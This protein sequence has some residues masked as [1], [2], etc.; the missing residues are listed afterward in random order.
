MKIAFFSSFYGSVTGGA[1]I[2]VSLLKQGLERRG[3]EIRVFSTKSDDQKAGIWHLQGSGVPRRFFILGSVLLD[4][5]IVLRSF[6]SLV[7]FS[8][9][10]I[11]AHDIYITPLAYFFAQKLKRPL[12]VTLRDQLQ[13]RIKFRNNY[14]VSYLPTEDYSVKQLS[15][16][17]FVRLFLTGF[18]KYFGDLNFLVAPYRLIRSGKVIECLRG[19]DKVIAIS[20]FINSEAQKMGI[21]PNNVVTIYNAAPDWEVAEGDST[22]EE[23][24][25]QVLRV[26]TLGRIAKEKGFHILIES[27]RMLASQNVGFSL[28][29]AGEGDY[30][31]SLRQLA[32]KLGISK[33]VEF[34]GRVDFHELKKYYLSCDV[35]VVPSLH[36]E[37][38]GRVIVEAFKCGKPVVGSKT[39][40]IPELIKP[41]KTGF[42]FEPG[43]SEELAE[44]LIKLAQERNI[45]QRMRFF[46][47]EDATTRFDYLKLADKVHRVYEGLLKE[48]GK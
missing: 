7:E 12:V 8:P 30:L 34:L 31:Q 18:V 11:H 2:S 9:D 39:G 24:K 4:K 22:G 32:Q 36:S 44:I 33:Q 1:E 25:E 27:C 14:L 40:G 47:L 16:E 35:V 38:F 41:G 37:P 19:A 45:L 17:E 5:L 23:K 43:N 6:S 21:A 3:D 20:N 42:L 29:V 13:P 15:L 48:D 46:C 28:T 26:F 10:I